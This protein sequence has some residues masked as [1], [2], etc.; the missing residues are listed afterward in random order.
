MIRPMVVCLLCTE[1]F[2][3]PLAAFADPQTPG[4]VT[5]PGNQG[6]VGPGAVSPAQGMPAVPATP[7]APASPSDP[8]DPAD[9]T[10]TPP[11]L[12]QTKVSGQFYSTPTYIS[13][14]AFSHSGDHVVVGFKDG[15]LGFFS[16]AKR[17]FSP[18]SESMNPSGIVSIALS[19]NSSM[20]AIGTSNPYVQ[21]INANTFQTIK[22]FKIGTNDSDGVLGVAFSP[23]GLLLAACAE[24]DPGD[25]TRPRGEV[26]IWSV[27]SGVRVG[28][29]YTKTE[30]PRSVAFSRDSSRLVVGGDDPIV[31]DVPLNAPLKII[32]NKGDYA[33]AISPD[34]R[35][36]ALPAQGGIV[37]LKTGTT[38]QC[39]LGS[40][41]TMVYTNDGR[42]IIG[43]S[44]LD[45]WSVFDG[46]S[47][48]KVVDLQMPDDF[49]SV[50]PDDQ[51]L[52]ASSDNLGLDI[53]KLDIP[54][55]TAT[56]SN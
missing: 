33:V 47:G 45:G 26:S 15:T 56:S 54:T 38:Q 25:F 35:Y 51:Y 7:A 14:M 18:F 50:S 43:G 6:L 32:P 30:S 5:S 42:Y 36:I 22:S 46:I 16:M 8:A 1:F 27:K 11:P 48:K 17:V 40:L 52:A 19:P 55:W 21:L 29:F 9:N 3:L 12:E 53:I 41:N 4:A 44:D 20:I 13:A 23:D 10:D 24:A 31:W 37:D 49:G 39:S 28:H 34:G 2:V